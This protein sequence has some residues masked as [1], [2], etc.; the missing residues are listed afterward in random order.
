MSQAAIP[1]IIS[2]KSKNQ[3]LYFILSVTA[4]VGFIAALA[5]VSIPL[6]WTPVPITGQTF[7]VALVS[8]LMGRRAAGATLAAYLGLGA[9]GVPVFAG[10]ASG[11]FF[12]PTLGYLLGMFV[13]AEVVGA[14]ADRGWGRKFWTALVACYAGSACTFAS[15]LLVLSYFVPGKELL[16]AGLLPFMIGD[17]IKNTLAASLASRFNP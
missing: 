1:A 4:G 14:L 17:L 5:Q 8:L 9:M 15:G 3:T 13:A 11:L 2:S 10:L 7:A 12:A 16:A 6:P